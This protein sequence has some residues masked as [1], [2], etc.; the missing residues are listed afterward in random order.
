MELI[1]KK[2]DSSNNVLLQE[3]PFSLNENEISE[4]WLFCVY[5]KS[6]IV[7]QNEAIIID[8]SHD[9]FFTNPSGI[10]YH[11]RCF[12]NADNIAAIGSPTEENS[13]FKGFGWTIANCICGMHLGWKFSSG[14]E[15]FYGL[16]ND[17]LTKESE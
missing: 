12:S 9:H 17:Y 4:G 14:G 8:S 3:N 15:V 1:L 16:V 13:W 7:K 10:K 11:V 6:R 5:C 2:Q